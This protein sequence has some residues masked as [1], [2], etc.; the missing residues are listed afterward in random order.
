MAWLYLVNPGPMTGPLWTKIGAVV[1]VVGCVVVGMILKGRIDRSREHRAVAEDG[2]PATTRLT[3]ANVQAPPRGADG[4]LRSRLSACDD[5]QPAREL[6]DC[7]ADGETSLSVV[8]D[9]SFAPDAPDAPTAPS[10][11]PGIDDR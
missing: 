4:A 2:G 9:G 3:S 10:P 1:F 7:A 5:A 11:P 8:R 6:L